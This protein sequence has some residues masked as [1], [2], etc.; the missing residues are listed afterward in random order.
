MEELRVRGN[1][2]FSN[3]P[4]AA[5]AIYQEA[6]QVYTTL[7]DKSKASALEEYTKCAG[8][9]LTCLFKLE[10][11]EACVALAYEVL[12]VNPL[13]AKAYAFIGRCAL[14]NPTITLPCQAGPLQYLCRA[15]HLLPTL[16]E[17]TLPFMEKAL[18][19]LLRERDETQ[20]ASE[21][22]EVC[23]EVRA[24]DC[25]K[26][27]VA[28]TRLP[29]MLAVSSTLQPFS[30]CVYED[31]AGRGVCAH[32]GIVIAVHYTAETTTG[33]THT[34]ANN[35]NNNNNN[36]ESTTATTVCRGCGLVAYCSP[37]CAAEHRQQHEQYECGPLR[38][39]RAVIQ[40]Q[41]QS[42]SQ[43]FTREDFAAAAHTISTIAA[44]RSHRPGHEALR[45][46]L[47][48]HAAVISQRLAPL[49]ALTHDLFGIN[50]A[51]NSSSEEAAFITHVLGV[52]RCNA[53]EVCDETGLGVG[54]ALYAD[55]ITSYFNHSC[56]P[57]CAIEAG[58][59]VT[60]RPI[61]PEEELTIAYIPQLYWPARLRREE[62]A[63]RYFFN[64]LCSRCSSSSKEN[65]HNTINKKN[66]TFDAALEATLSSGFKEKEREHLAQVQ[67][68]C[69]RIRDKEV[70]EVDGSDRDALLRLMKDCRQ[71][72]FPFHYLFQELRNTLTF[73]YAVLGDT[74]AC[75]RS[76]LEELLL[77][78]AIVPGAHPVKRLKVQ[79]ALRCLE[80][81]NEDESSRSISEPYLLQPL[82]LKF[83]S[84]YGIS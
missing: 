14:L 54:Q 39:L 19:E 18:D 10:E 27:V 48:S 47:Q 55:S 34:M 42:Q 58:A 21:S 63:D 80:E 57:N 83:A 68:L 49:V 51:D 46:Q 6:L 75:L 2:L 79:N 59:I 65:N 82:L 33:N 30:V 36:N 76:C 77:W 32:C 74:A 62:L 64:C 28:G 56:T 70:D 26:C 4:R 29:A 60:T 84:L 50:A 71:H 1:A 20:C 9:A 41:S 61:A 72:L 81:E 67:L 16:G 73:V 38:R 11:Y 8:N 40:T 13:I 7:D 31:A 35:N 52:V 24:G 22:E 23:V 43:T 17:A 69:S 53:L 15:V 45:Q 66:D 44:A 37:D 78:E 12:N 25:G 5:A 3:D